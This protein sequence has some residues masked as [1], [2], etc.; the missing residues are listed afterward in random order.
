[1]TLVRRRL[2]L[3]IAFAVAGWTF[4]LLDSRIPMPSSPVVFWAGNL[5]SPWIVLPF[6]AGWAQRSRG[7]ALASGLSA[8]TASM[9]GFF[10]PG[11]GWGPASP[12]FV[13]GWLL[14]GALS[15]ALY[16]LFGERWGRSRTL[17]DGLAL[18]LPFILEPFAWR[19]LGYSQGRLPVWYAE[20][21]VGLGLLTWVVAASRRRALQVVHEQGRHDGQVDE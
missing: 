13:T 2:L 19:G 7:W 18:A 1:M 15:G 12:G 9:A 21:A 14:V 16:G 17:P 4:G 6:L 5:G 8:C 10:G 11:G 3:L 20:V